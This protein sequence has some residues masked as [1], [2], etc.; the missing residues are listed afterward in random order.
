MHRHS[1]V[2]RVPPQAIARGNDGLTQ[3]LLVA[4]FPW[5]NLPKAADRHPA[6]VER[7]PRIA[8]SSIDQREST[9]AVA[10]QLVQSLAQTLKLSPRVQFKEH[11]VDLLQLRK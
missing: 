1:L 9:L 5:K 10:N 4:V 11:V 6:A 8:T 3:P 2:L 7:K